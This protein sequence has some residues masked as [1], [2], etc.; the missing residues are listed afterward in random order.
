MQFLT[1]KDLSHVRVLTAQEIVTLK[2][3]TH[4]KQSLLTYI[5]NNGYWIECDCT[6]PAALMTVR[7]KEDSH[8]LVNLNTGGTHLKTC[9][10]ASIEKDSQP[11]KIAKV[12]MKNAFILH[13]GQ[14]DRAADPNAAPTLT[15][16]ASNKKAEDSLF[17]LISCLFESAQIN[18]FDHK[19]PSD[20]KTKVKH[21]MTAAKQFRV[22]GKSLDSVLF[23]GITQHEKAFQS[24][25]KE[26]NQAKDIARVPMRVIISVIDEF[27]VSDFGLKVV[28]HVYTSQGEKRTHE[29]V[30]TQE[31]K[32][33]LASK[34]FSAKDSPF[35][36]IYTLIYDTK[37][38][39][40]YI[41]P[42]RA[43]IKPLASYKNLIPVDNIA[44]RESINYLEEQLKRHYRKGK[45]IKVEKP[46]L[47]ISVKDSQ[48]TVKPDII[49]STPD[50]RVI[51][52][53]YASDDVNYIEVRDK[54]HH[55]MQQLADTLVISPFELKDD[56]LT[57]NN[58]L[59]HE[60][61]NQLID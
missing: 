10:F 13:K 6:Q 2:A 56:A 32:I 16:G 1:K 22:G 48:V 8:H 45:L 60:S 19:T 61:L 53:L 57:V 47:D 18:V 35:I 4:T 26:V 50:K 38:D 30:L 27:V 17:K 34:R 9:Y 31:C 39:A 14:V 42:G 52:N 40:N 25:E 20:Y 36:L 29:V 59:L 46:L 43:Y 44:E 23:W 3:D 49:I 58:K 28:S 7:L 33:T 21:I 41:R 24:L 11:Q 51:V 15:A 54:L 55:Y 5:R 37:E 12:G